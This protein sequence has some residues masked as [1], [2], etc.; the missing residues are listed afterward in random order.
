VRELWQ[1]RRLRE[2]LA[3]VETPH[4]M[5]L[6]TKRVVLCSNLFAL[7]IIAELVSRGFPPILNPTITA[8]VASLVL[9]WV[10]GDLAVSVVLATLYFFP[11]L[12]YAWFNAFNFSYYTIWLTALV[13]AMLPKSARSRWAFPGRFGPPLVLWA[14]VLASSWPILLLREVDFVPAL[15]NDPRAVAASLPQMPQVIAVWILSVTTI[16]T[17]SLLLLDWL[18]VAYRAERHDPGQG[19]SLF[20]RLIIQ[21]LLATAAIAAGVAVYQSLVDLKFLNLTPW[22]A[23]GRATGTLRDANAFAAIASMWLPLAL[24]LLIATTRRFWRKAPLFLTVFFLFGL[25]LW[26]SG[27][28]SGF[29]A[30]SLGVIVLLAHSWRAI[31]PVHALA[32]VAGAV[33]L[34][35]V[36]MFAVPASV[37]TPWQRYMEFLERNQTVQDAVG[38]LWSRGLYGTAALR[39]IAEHPYVGIG[40]GGFHYQYYEFLKLSETAVLTGGGMLPPDNAQ[41]WY[42]QQLAELGVLG[43]LGWL[44]SGALLVWILVRRRGPDHRRALVGAVKGSLV[45]FGII[46][47]LGVPGQDVAVSVTFIAL[48]CWCLKLTAVD[49][50]PPADRAPGLCAVEW[51]GI[52][53]VSA[54]F[55]GG[56][57]YM[58]RGELR[59]P[60]RAQRL[61]IPY[62]YGFMPDPDR[63]DIQW[64]TARAVDVVLRE[65]RWMRVVLADVAPD[66]AENPVDV[67]MSLNGE[68]ILHV[69]RRA[70]FP[71]TRWIR[72]PDSRNHAMIEIRVGRTWRA[73]DF[74]KGADRQERGIAVHPWF[75]SDDDPA[76]GSLTI[77]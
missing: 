18:F 23:L 69:R 9:A 14:L 76:K 49:S 44:V 25:G 5:S 28:R 15:L 33:A 37:R 29:L 8:F 45:G 20:E 12:C 4:R 10:V 36:A 16:A 66:A 42:R 26:G 64:T 55:I 60:L 31:R 32:G 24:G 11:A 53:I 74:G 58:A 3:R 75:F 50:V 73:A 2:L 7:W 68:Q 6:F 62:R 38:Q 1:R 47:L 22:P 59:P 43:S 63:P 40:V 70:H 19:W 17:T 21:P 56:T 57:I 13:G 65:K 39:M 41:S 48:V 34:I 35:T 51:A 67:K 46:S 54:A 30:A 72:L 52:L 77:E 71:I 61:D 27:T